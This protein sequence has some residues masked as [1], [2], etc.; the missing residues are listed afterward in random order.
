MESLITEYRTAHRGR[1]PRNDTVS[2]WANCSIFEADQ[3]LAEYRRAHG[4]RVRKPKTGTTLGRVPEISKEKEPDEGTVGTAEGSSKPDRRDRNRWDGVLDVGALALAV[5][6]DL[7]LNLVVFVTIA[8]DLWTQIGMGALAFVVVAFG[9]RGWIKGGVIGKT[10]WAT[11]ALVATFSDLSFALYAT[12]VQTQSAGQD[13]ELVRLTDKVDHDQKILDELQAGYNSIGSGFRSELAERQR[14]IEAA[15]K[16]LDSSS[17]KRSNYI[18]LHRSE[19]KGPA[20]TAGGLF[21][22]IPDACTRGRWIQLV[23]FGLLFVGLQSTL[24][25]SATSAK[26]RME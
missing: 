6:I 18:T 5:V 7:L 2:K 8:P 1:Y 4:D 15:R 22:A 24:V 3:I 16:A 11:F 21:S 13:S 19:A 10:L 23:F 25:V 20:L 9:L 14:A 17:E 26:G 12:D